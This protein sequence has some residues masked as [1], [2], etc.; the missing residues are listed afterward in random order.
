MRLYTHNQIAYEAAVTM[1]ESH[2]RA[3]VIHPTGTGKSFLAFQ[4]IEDHPDDRFLWLSPNDYIFENQQRN[5]ERQ[6][7]NVE[8]M[9]YTKLLRLPE[10][11]LMALRPETIILDEFHRCGAYCWGQG[12]ERLLRVYPAAKVLGLSATPIRYLDNCRNMAEELFTVDSRLCVASEMTLGEAIV[13]GILP[14]PRYVTTMLRYQQ[15]LRR[16]QKRIDT[17]VP[18]GMKEPSQRCL[19]AL[20]RALSRADGLETIFARWLKKGEKYIIFC[21]DWAHVQEVKESIPGWFREVDSDPQCYCL[22]AGKPETEAEYEAF[23][24]DQSDHIKLLLCINRLNEGV[25]VPDV[26]GVILF[27]PTSSPILYKQ[28]IGRVLTAG[29][30]EAPLILDIVNNF[31]GL[32]SIGTI[33]MEMANAVHK[34]RQTGQDSLIRVETF[35]IEEQ[36]EDSAHLVRELEN[37]LSNTWDMWYD[38]ARSYY[39]E[40]GNLKVPKRYVTESGMQLGV[41]IQTQRAIH[42]GSGKGELSPERVEALDAIGMVWGNLPDTAW[43]EAWELAR[44][45]YFANGDLLVPDS[46]MIG[47]FDLGKWVAY[48]RNRRKSGKLLAD[49]VA[50]LEEI[51][52]VWDVFDARWEMHYRQAKAYFEAHGHLDIPCS[53]RTEDGFL[54]GMWVVGQRKV[55]L[56][57]GKG[58]SLTQAQIDRL[59]AIGMVWDGTFDTQWQSAY[60]RAEEYYRQNGNLNIPYVY[61]TPDGYQLG[62]WLARQKSAKKA[63]GKHSNCVMTTERIAK[64]EDIGVVWDAEGWNEKASCGSSRHL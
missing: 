45:Y 51:G 46:L 5:A 13:R 52:M 50:R 43:N 19:D 36:V 32:T 29:S 10:D 17:L 63:P 4:L 14:A 53:Y 61:C 33:R 56:G 48:Q 1:L 57:D 9:T 60:A 20:R 62:K 54:L 35:Q 55:R 11:V 15:E 40:H 25:H 41:W 38:E 16:Y 47:G 6:F 31:D 12:V 44:E 28:Q 37:A 64:L 39:L 30:T 7:P 34:L 23:L 49:R 24:A 22:Y 2:R 27:R 18:R 3:A 26:S 58:K 42:G 21:A 8:F 59:N